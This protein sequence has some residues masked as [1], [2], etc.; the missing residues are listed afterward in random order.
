MYT[1][2]VLHNRVYARVKHDVLHE[3]Q[4]YRGMIII[5]LLIVTRRLKRIHYNRRGDGR[6]RCDRVRLI[7]TAS[8]NETTK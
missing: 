5:L 8:E 6:S 7:F 3:N 1:Y 4:R 2:S